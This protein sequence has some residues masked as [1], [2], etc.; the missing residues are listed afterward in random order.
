MKK[1]SLYVLLV[2]IFS[3]FAS[4]SF[5]AKK[6]KIYKRLPCSFN[7][8]KVSAS[9]R[10]H[11]GVKGGRCCPNCSA[12]SKKRGTSLNMR[13]GTPIVAIA[14]MKVLQIKDGSS[15]Q[16]DSKITRSLGKKH[17]VDTYIKGI[18][19]PFDDVMIYFVDKQ[20]NVV[21][22]YHL[23]ETPLVPGFNKGK[24]KIPVEYNWERYQ[25]AED[26]GG[27]SKE[28]IN[29]NFWVKKG[30]VI[31][32]SG[33][34]GKEKGDKHIS[35]GIAV[36]PTEGIR[37]FIINITQNVTKNNPIHRTQC[38]VIVNDLCHKDGKIIPISQS[39]REILIMYFAI[40]KNKED[41]L[42]V[43][44]SEKYL[45]MSLA[46]DMAM[47]RCKLF[48]KPHG[49]NMQEACYIDSFVKVENASDIP[50]EYGLKYNFFNDLY[51]FTGNNMRYT[52]PQRDF[53]WENLP[54]DS[55]AYLFPVMSKK[56]LKEIGYYK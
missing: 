8:V 47:K 9:A 13:R 32:L 53:K 29:N 20:G 41:N 46:K 21:L 48:F 54:T 30:Q 35:L 28:L 16:R 24:C 36:P 14:D 42:V 11:D 5:A 44:K 6:H 33:A 31:G 34:T 26:C 12:Y 19:K 51:N 17:G 56:Y 22:Y 25:K 2:L 7:G 37:N 49:K 3:L 15:E 38:D 50:S 55:D 27:Y 23:K 45:S 4:H 43:I 52:A 39:K 10:L 1:L 40:A 18:Q